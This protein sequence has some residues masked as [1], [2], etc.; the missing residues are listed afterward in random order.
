M[1]MWP[2]SKP[3]GIYCARCQHCS[4]FLAHCC[5]ESPATG[6][7][8]TRRVSGILPS[9]Y[10]AGAP[11]LFSRKPVRTL[12]VR[13]QPRTGLREPVELALAGAL[14]LLPLRPRKP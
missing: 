2:H 3:V 4:Q 7:E 8:A 10:A 6:A 11:I 14:G 9:E 13:V 12:H 1:D 5:A